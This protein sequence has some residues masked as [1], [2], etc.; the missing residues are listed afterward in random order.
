M[1][2]AVA[3]EPA[4]IDPFDALARALT[5]CTFDCRSRSRPEPIDRSFYKAFGT[6]RPRRVDAEGGLAEHSL[7][8]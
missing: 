1:A 6:V 8:L 2:A 5:G 7:A 4:A 3:V